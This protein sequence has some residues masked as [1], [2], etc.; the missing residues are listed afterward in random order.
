[1]AFYIES[2]VIYIT[3][4]D[5]AVLEVTGIATEGG[6]EYTLQDGDVLTLTVREL[7]SAESPALIR[8]D[9]LP[10]SRRIVFS[11]E[12]TAGL[13]VGRYSADVQLTTAED[14][15][16]TLWPSISGSGRY[17]VRNLNNFVVMPEVTIL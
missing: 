1:M 6:E 16:Y 8:I 4:G 2:G 13:D 11:H 12:D 3:R 10:G 14:R 7:P 5:D 15:H 9:A 17:K